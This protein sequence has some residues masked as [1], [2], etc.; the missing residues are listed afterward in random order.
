MKRF[1]SAAILFSM[2]FFGTGCGNSSKN[3]KEET[4]DNNDTETEADI[5]SDEDETDDTEKDDSEE[6]DV[7]ETAPEHSPEDEAKLESVSILAEEYVRFSHGTGVVIGYGIDEL[8]SLAYGVR[9]SKTQEPLSTD[10]LFDIGSIT[11]NFTAV[12]LLLLQ[13]DGKIDLDQTIDKWFPDFEKGDIITVRMLLNHTSGILEWNEF[14]D[15]EG[16]VEKVNGKFNFEP[17]TDWSYSNTN[18][19]IA[20]LIINRITG[21]DAVEVIREKILDPLGMTHTFM[22]NFEEYPLEEKAHGHTF[23]E[24]GNIVPYELNERFWTAGGIISNVEDM[25]KYAHALFNEDLIS[26]ESLDQMLDMVKVSGVPVYGLAMMYGN[27]HHGVFYYHG[28]DVITTAAMLAYY[29][30]TGEIH[31]LF[32]NGGTGSSTLVLLNDEIDFVLTDGKTAEKQSDFPDWDKLIDNE[33]DSQIFALYAPLPDY[34]LEELNDS[35]G[36]FV[37]PGDYFPDFYCSHY[38]FKSLGYV[39]IVQQCMEPLRYYTDD[40][41]IR[42]TDIDMYLS[43]FEAAAE[44]GEAT[45]NFYVTKYDYY[46]DIE[47]DFVTK[48]CYDLEESDPDKYMWIS[49]G[50]HPSGTEYYSVWGKSKMAESVRATGCECYDK[51]ENV[52]E[53]PENDETTENESII[54]NLPTLL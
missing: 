51:D 24:Y 32:N 44:A 54:P 40:L 7:D 27:G 12:T 37:Y 29:P 10:D 25:F 43:E 8:T 52:T 38:M 49:R 2:I 23:D 50:Q 41:K 5:E 18:F 48:I 35:I 21:K 28:G 47:G 1:L 16:M 46:Y 45:Q 31:V 30:E 36:Y 6:P 26:K 15:L 14:D 22:K 39:K 33:D 42:R 4:P 17:G 34:P 11:K 53:C 3:E 20:G 19:V 13:E 9:N